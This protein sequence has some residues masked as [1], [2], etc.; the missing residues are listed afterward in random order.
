MKA[1]A[2]AAGEVITLEGGLKYIGK[3]VNGLPNG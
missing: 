2:G 3:L 1:A